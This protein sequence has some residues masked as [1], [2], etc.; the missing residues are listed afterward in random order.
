[1]DTISAQSQTDFEQHQLEM[2]LWHAEIHQRN[3]KKHE[4][5]K[6]RD[7]VAGFLRP[8]SEKT[9]LQPFRIDHSVLPRD[10]RGSTEQSRSSP[11]CG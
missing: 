1:M 9:G 8:E 10:K 3:G 11:R 2:L 4:A 6:I 5:S 7:W